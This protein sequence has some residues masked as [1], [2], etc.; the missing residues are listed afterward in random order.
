[1]HVYLPIYSPALGKEHQ[2]AF[3]LCV[4][5]ARN[6]KPC[7]GDKF[8]ALRAYLATCLYSSVNVTLIVAIKCMFPP[9]ACRKEIA[10]VLPLPARK[11]RLVRLPALTV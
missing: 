7:G 4:L 2:M 1:M 11:P 3:M 8:P 9:T 6:L 5:R 10:F